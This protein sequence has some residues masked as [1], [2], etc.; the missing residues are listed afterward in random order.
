MKTVVER[1]K[2]CI[3]FR[4]TRVLIIVIFLAITQGCT[5]FVYISSDPFLKEY[6]VP[7]EEIG[8][9][10]NGTAVPDL[11][12]ISKET[13]NDF[14]E[15]QLR[16]TDVSSAV[17]ISQDRMMIE[18]AESLI[19]QFPQMRFVFVAWH[20]P[21]TVNTYTD[22]MPEDVKN[23]GRFIRYNTVLELKCDTMLFDL[24]QKV[25]IAK[26]VDTFRETR[27]SVISKKL[28]HLWIFSDYPEP[29]TEIPSHGW[30]S[31]LKRFLEDISSQNSLVREQLVWKSGIKRSRKKVKEYFKG[32]SLT[33]EE[34]TP[35]VTLK[36]D[37]EI[38]A[39]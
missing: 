22:D 32:K 7:E 24:R 33:K 27:S 23:K 9:A 20:N 37:G 28:D 10:T 13:I 2:S 16:Y 1:S 38:P 26:S 39:F 3:M 34:L 36:S 6:F 25:L 31:H 17:S 18:N 14:A 12:L 11:F 30:R 4:A 5:N 29:A 21:L 19:E 8:I 35:N 15:Q